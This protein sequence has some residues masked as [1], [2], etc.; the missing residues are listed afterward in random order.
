MNFAG[1]YADFDT[2][3]FNP[4]HIIAPRSLASLIAAQEEK[5]AVAKAEAKAQENTVEAVRTQVE[6]EEAV[7]EAREKAEEPQM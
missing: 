3:G 2:L 4:D 5:E 6:Q 7:E 1:D